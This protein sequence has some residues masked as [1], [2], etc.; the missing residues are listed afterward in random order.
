[1]E[2]LVTRALQ[3]IFGEELSFHLVPSVKGSQAVIT[4]QLE[5]RRYEKE[6]GLERTILDVRATDV[7]FLG[8]RSDSASSKPAVESPDEVPF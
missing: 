5:P 3:V 1:M 8:G 2:G 6:P 4:G 7:G